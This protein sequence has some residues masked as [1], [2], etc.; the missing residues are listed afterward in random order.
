MRSPASAPLNRFD[1][2][3]NSTP[4]RVGF[5]PERR[6]SI[7]VGE[8]V[9]DGLRAAVEY[10][11]VVDYDVADGGTG[12]SANAFLYQLTYEY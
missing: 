9:L 1:W 7:G 10:A 12:N 2:P 11:H 3:A 6:F 4:L 5:V 8:W